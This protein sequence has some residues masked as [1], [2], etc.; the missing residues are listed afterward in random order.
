[1]TKHPLFI[2]I[3]GVF[4]GA[5]IMVKISVIVPVYNVENYLT[6]CL[7]SVL[8]QTVKD[9]EI[10]AVDDGSTDN[11][12]SVLNTLAKK[13]SRI[14]VFSH[15]N[16]GVSATRNFALE[17][18]KGD[19]ISFL[20]SD[21][22]LA[23]DFLE[24]L[25]QSLLDNKEA[26]FA[27]CGFVASETEVEFIKT[28]APQLTVQNPFNHF[29]LRKKPRIDATTCPKLYRKEVLKGLTF[30][31]EFSVGEDLVFLYQ[32]LH[33][34][35]ACV[36]VPEIMYFYR[37]R[38]TSAIHKPITQKRLSDE[39]NVTKTLSL[40]FKDNIK[41]KQTQK[42]FEKYISNRFMRCVFKMPKK[43]KNY[44]SWVKEFLPIL[45]QFEKENIFNPR[46][47]Q[48]KN[49]VKYIFSKLTIR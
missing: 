3:E 45:K 42:V 8:N 30:P 19:Y 35:K 1:M 5:D 32:V 33:R 48:I 46:H 24:T 22:I 38:S 18:A 7:N 9:F 17:Q 26:D 40:L 20:D 21:D 12:L 43:D 34:A 44:Q 37:T 13:D 10:I 16:K 4:F 49:K 41:D 39:L 15:S 6:A 36:L 28:G 29:V 25:Y 27:S 31:P 2:I 11:S 23:P 14:K 47:L